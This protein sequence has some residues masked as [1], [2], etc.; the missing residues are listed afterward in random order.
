[1][2]NYTLHLGIFYMPWS[3]DMGPTAL[4]SLRRNACWGF[5]RPKNTTAS[6]GCEPANLGTKGQHSSRPPKLLCFGHTCRP[7]SGGILY[8]YNNWYV[9]CFFSWL[10][11]GRPT[12]SQLKNTKHVNFHSRTE[13]LDIIKVLWPTDAQGFFKR[14]I[15]IYIK[16]APTCFGVITII[17]ERTILAC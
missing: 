11:V 1:M 12:D 14:I 10:S 9:L 5:F 3:Y 15:K 13:H 4:L 17:R 6:A 16:T 7:S 2:P 8:V